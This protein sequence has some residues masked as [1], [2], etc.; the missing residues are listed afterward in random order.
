MQLSPTGERVI[1][2]YYLSNPE[3]Y[4]IYQFHLAT[5]RYSFPFVIGKHVLDLGC[6][7]G[8]GT[9]LIAQQGANVAGVDI[10]A[11]AISYARRHYNRTNLTFMV[12]ENVEEFP[13]PFSDSSFDVVLSF[14]VI[15]HLNDPKPY[16][17]DIQ[18][19][20]KPSG[21]LLLA[22]PDR[23]E[24]LFSFQKPWNVWH[25]HEYQSSALHQLLNRYF[26]DVQVLRMGGKEEI[27]KTELDRIRKIRWLTLPFTFPFTSE[28]VR[29]KGLL[30]LKRLNAAR[31]GKKPPDFEPTALGPGD[32]VISPD[33]SPSVNLVAIARR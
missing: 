30:W 17:Q 31:R 26:S 19:V 29:K 28:R 21:T 7:S 11:D 3:D 2:E 25:V 33:Q 20:L 16:L 10:S 1:E 13:L 6:G 5:Y 23:S 14:Q 22:T 27:L 9:D 18:R 15:E 12:V 8:Y 24:R 32:I 4:L